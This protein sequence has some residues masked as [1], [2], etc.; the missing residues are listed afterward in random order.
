MAAPFPFPKFR[1]FSETGSPLAGGKLYSYVAGTTT[2]Q[3]TY[4][5]A[6]PTVLDSNGEASVWP[7]PA[8]SYKLVLKDADGVEQWTVDSIIP[9]TASEVLTFTPTVAFGGSSTGITYSQQLGYYFTIGNAVF[10]SALITLTNK[11]SATG[12]MTVS[13]LPLTAASN[14]GGSCT[15]LGS[16]ITFGGKYLAATINAS[17]KTASIWNVPSAGG[18]TILADTAFANNSVITL[19]GFYTVAEVPATSVGTVPV[20]S[21]ITIAADQTVT[22]P[23]T[24]KINL[25]TII[26]DPNSEWNTSTHRYSPLHTGVYIINAKFNVVAATGTYFLVYLMVN[27]SVTDTYQI[28]ATAGS[29]MTLEFT[30]TRSFTGTSDYVEFQAFVPGT[31]G[32]VYSGAGSSRVTITRIS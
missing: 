4:T 26:A 24:P 15:V 3:N 11:G 19:E 10:F 2:P 8:V 31:T 18:A 16:N 1:A 23:A 14:G 25:D 5:D 20:V 21:S 30:T 17:T 22:N 29:V 9:S 13:N 32:T 6:N 7:A 12:N 27:G 28:N